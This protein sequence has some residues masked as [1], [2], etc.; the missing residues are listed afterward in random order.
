[1]N[2]EAALIKAGDKFLIESAIRYFNDRYQYPNVRNGEE[3][4][5]GFSWRPTFHFKIFQHLT[6]AAEISEKPYPMILSLRHAD[7]MSLDIPMSIYV[8]CT[9]ESY[10]ADIGEAKRLMNDGYGLITVAAD[11]NVFKQN[12]CIP[13]IQRIAPKEFKSSIKS[14]PKAIRARLSESY[15]IYENNAP[16]GV[17]H[18]TE[19]MEGLVLKAGKDAVQKKWITSAD[20]KSGSARILGAL[21]GSGTH[22]KNASAA[23]GGAESYISQYRNIAHHYPN[24]AKKAAKKYRDCRH[25]FLDGIRKIEFFRDAVRSAGLSGRL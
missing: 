19:V 21:R 15:N 1:M 7:I 8:V 23:I 25:G 20:I 12:N 16:A 13:L 4:E 11:G 22:L 5:K 9:E 6:V 24:N 10:K 2:A 17:T 18:I 3:V 14:L